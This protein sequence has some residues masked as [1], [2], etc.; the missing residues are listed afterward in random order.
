ML[1][2][3]RRQFLSYSA[4]GLAMAAAGA[5]SPAAFAAMGPDDKFDLA[6]QGRRGA[7]PQPEVRAKRDI[8]IRH[9][10]WRRWKPI[11]PPTRR[12]GF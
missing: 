12:T 6:G 5:S 4:S 3:S 1:D 10:G 8:G 9:G 7:R 11:F 2:V